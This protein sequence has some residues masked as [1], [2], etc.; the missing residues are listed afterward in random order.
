MQLASRAGR[1]L[2]RIL[3]AQAE[4]LAP[5]PKPG[6]APPQAPPPPRPSAQR[7]APA[8]GPRCKSSAARR[9]RRAGTSG[10]SH[11]GPGLHPW[12]ELGLSLGN[13]GLAQTLLDPPLSLGPTA[14][15]PPLCGARVQLAELLEADIELE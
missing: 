7:A 13:A 10:E 6:P 12:G 2:L 3:E 4:P 8:P 11:P 1:Q 14:C 15:C 5:P 9:G